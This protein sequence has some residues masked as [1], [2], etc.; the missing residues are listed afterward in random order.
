MNAELFTAIDE[1]E[2]ERGLPQGFL[3]ERLE[4]ALVAALKKFVPGS[5][6]SAHVDIDPTTGNIDLYTARTVVEEVENSKAEISLEEAREISGIYNLGDVV[7][8]DVDIKDF[9]RVAAQVAKQVI[10]SGLREAERNKIYEA[11][12]EKEGEVISGK[13]T[14]IDMK[15]GKITIQV[16]AGQEAND[17]FLMASDCIPGESLSEGE[18]VKVFIQEVSSSTKGPIARITRRA[19]EL[20]KRLFELE[21]PEIAEGTV[22]INRI[23]REPGSRS[24]VAVR[25]LS[26]DIDAIGACIGNNGVRINAITSEL[27]NEKIDIVEFSENPEKFVSNALAPCQVVRT[28]RLDEET[29]GGAPARHPSIR[30]IVPDSQLSLAIGREGQNVRLAARLTGCKIDIKP[31]TF[32]D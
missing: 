13:I 27:A 8:T 20:V 3:L 28:L 25:S 11:F 31:E 19:P 12:S 24:K 4:L 26:S 9:S 6:E 29:E 5:D 17:A 2:R 1:L 18:I 15:N 16:G 23:A 10:V 7:R 14:H 22:E 21:I 30:A 32:V